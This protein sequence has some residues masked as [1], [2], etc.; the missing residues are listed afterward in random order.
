MDFR[1]SAEKIHVA[2]KSDKQ[3]RVLYMN[4]NIHFLSYLVQFFLEWETFQLKFVQEIKFYV[5]WVLFS[6]IVSFM[7]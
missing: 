6:K 4:T 7:R 2:L 1:K 3:Q 5:Q